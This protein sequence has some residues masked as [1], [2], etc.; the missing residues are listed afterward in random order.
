MAA[1]HEMTASTAA[2]V[3]GPQMCSRQNYN[4]RLHLERTTWAF[5]PA[6]G[7]CQQVVDVCMCVGAAFEPSGE[8]VAPVLRRLLALEQRTAYG[9]MAPSAEA[10]RRRVRGGALYAT[11]ALLNHDCLPNV[12]RCASVQRADI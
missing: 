12:A 8:A 1:L 4:A 6:G 9:I 2:V 3:P 7:P 11:A 10:G 5:G